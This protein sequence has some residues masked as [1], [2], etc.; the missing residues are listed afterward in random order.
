[1][2][3]EEKNL[4]WRIPVSFWGPVFLFAALSL[5]AGSGPSYDLLALALCGYYLCARWHLRGCVYALILI[6]LAA[7]VKHTL[8]GSDHLWHLGLEGSLS[9]SLFLAALGVE[10]ENSQTASLTAQIETGKACLKN[11][12]EE[13]EQA[14]QSATLQHTDLQDKIGLL[15]KEIEE[16]QADFSSLGILNDVLRKTTARYKEEKES[17]S[18]Q[19]IDLQ[20]RIGTLQSELVQ[21]Q[22]ELKRVKESDAL[23]LENQKLM[24]ELNAA[25]YD[26]EQ[27]HLIN[28]TLARL[29]AKENLRARE[30]AQRI[31][32]ILA[33]KMQMQARMQEELVATRTE[34]KIY[35]GNHEQTARELEKTRQRVRELDEVQTQ[36][37][38]LQERLQSA[39]G[40]I[41]V[42]RQKMSLPQADPR[43]NEK[44]GLLE[45]ERQELGERL[46][47]TEEKV[48]ALSKIEPLYKQLKKQFEEKN[49][50]LHQ[51]R[52]EL[53]KA[54]TEL[55]R[56]LLEKDQNSLHFNPFPKEAVEEIDALHLQIEE[57]EEENQELQEIINALSLTEPFQ[58][59]KKKVKTLLPDQDFLF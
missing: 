8:I 32:T 6:T 43:L 57:I 45:Q 52:S 58:K 15:Q 55:Q 21:N 56:L 23:A 41:A 10:W 53:F 3:R 18:E 26:K 24:K 37:N 35:S 49:E 44:I 2:K 29:H 22:K 59:R 40:E 7:I 34:A 33:E 19:S 17:L 51:V 16:V 27:T 5:S 9:C 47:H 13:F 31:E 25:R 28:E 12:E 46:V 38:F 48:H 1:M 36:R 54:D 20:H 50:I 14:R 11:V 39:E 4:F 30:S 42:L